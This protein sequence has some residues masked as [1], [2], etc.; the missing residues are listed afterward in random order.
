MV[1]VLAKTVDTW[2]RGTDRARLQLN[3]RT[4]FE[5]PSSDSCVVY[6][7]END[8]KRKTVLVV[9][10]DGSIRVLA[11]RCLVRAGFRVLEAADGLQ[12][13]EVL[14]QHHPDIILLDIEMPEL[15]GFDTC[16]RVRAIPEYATVPILIVTGLDD[17][18]SVEKAFTAGATDFTTKP[19]NWT[20]L[21]H[22]VSY[23]LRAGSALARIKQRSAKLREAKDQAEE[24]NRAK[25]AFLANMS[26]EMRTPMHA[27]LSFSGIGAKRDGGNDNYYEK[28]AQSGKRLLH[29]LDNLL[30]LSKLEAGRMELD[31]KHHHVEQV[32]EIVILEFQ[33]LAQE[34]GLRLVT[35]IDDSVQSWC[36]DDVRIVQVI[37]NLVSNAIKFSADGEI[38][39][40]VFP[41]VE[42]SAT[43]GPAIGIS[44]EDF[45]MGI[46]VDERDSVFDKFAQSSKTRAAAGG[47]GLGLAI[48]KE[49]VE[50]HG[51]SIEIDK[52][53][54][55]GTCVSFY[56]PQER[57][58][59]QNAV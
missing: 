4:D 10:D 32:V 27:I 44:V 20:L 21:P 25:S 11:S 26:H 46:P 24:A 28:I 17:T 3:H 6:T 50:L 47:T 18:R 49:I 12:A 16:A 33:S 39:V 55:T 59:L 14:Q 40:R 1:K 5:S 29:L 2:K 15:D 52:E 45:G 19:I 57:I 22:R 38:T 54:I 7:D 35:Q 13:L 48:C 34:R 37:R 30:D 51:G 9:D 31:T 36:M 42:Y 53:R 23:L 43:G 58:D 56:I 8:D 41:V